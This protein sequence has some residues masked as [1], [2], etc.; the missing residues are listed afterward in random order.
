MTAPDGIANRDGAP[1]RILLVEVNIDG[2]SGGS[3]QAMFD[4]ARHLDPSRYTPVALFYQNNSFVD[5]LRSLGVQVIIW[6]E[7]WR[8]EH[9]TPSRWFTPRRVVGL[10]QAIS[11]RVA[12]LR[13][14]R[15]DLV[16]MNNS[17]SYGYLDWL[18]AARMLGIPCVTHLRGDL[19]PIKGE[20]MRWLNCRFD[21]YIAIS[22]YMKGVLESER[23][24][25][26]RILQ[27]ED[28]IDIDGLR[29]RVTRSRSAVRA[30]LGVVDGALL[31]V[32]VGHL[33]TWKGQDVVLRAL[34]GLEPPLRARLHVAFVG[35]DDRFAPEFRQ[36]LDDLVRTHGLESSVSFLGAR[37]DVPEL[38][39]AA[40]LVVH[41]STRPEPFGL[42]VVEGMALGRLV[43][44]AALGGPAQILGDGSGWTFDPQ[45]PAELTELLRR[46]ILDPEVAAKYGEVALARAQRFTI[47]QTTNQM[48]NVYDELLA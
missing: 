11:R 46:V 5:R 14:E 47:Q 15:I 3:H 35:A 18:P 27:I 22:G 9:G 36:S 7:V 6:E 25:R 39:N 16:H 42:V 21:R 26:R 4:L 37:T 41:A 29:R 13:R 48:Q 24:P 30:E 38:M 45:R 28:G 43:I 20:L 31:A 12:L 19:Y 17:P 8:R 23:F 33:R 34:G 2:T 10:A 1:R 44:A 32:M 40:D